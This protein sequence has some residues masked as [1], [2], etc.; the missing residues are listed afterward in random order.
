MLKDHEIQGVI[1][2]DNLKELA[3]SFNEYIEKIISVFNKNNVETE[4]VFNLLY[5]ENIRCYALV[6]L[7]F[8]LIGEKLKSVYG[9]GIDI[10]QLHREAAVMLTNNWPEIKKNTSDYVD[11]SRKINDIFNK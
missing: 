3:A 1:R 4:K 6:T 7:T 11:L 10:D 5:E 2:T 9:L 8:K